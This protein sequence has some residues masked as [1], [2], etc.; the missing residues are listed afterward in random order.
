MDDWYTVVEILPPPGY[1]SDTAPKDVKLEP[2]KATQIK[3]DN[4][5]KPVLVFLKTNG[6]TG[7]GIPGATFRV[8]YET[9]GG[10]LLNIGSYKTDSSGRIII[11]LVNPGWYVLTETL[12]ANG[13]SLPQNPV[14]RLYVSAGQNAYLPEFDKYYGVGANTGQ[15]ATATPPGETHT[16]EEHSG[17]EYYVQGEG[18]NWPLN[19][20]VIKKTHAITGELLAGAAF[21]LYRADE[22]VSGVPGTAVGRYTVDNSGI[23]VITGLLPGYYVV[24]EVQAPQNFLISEN[25]QQNG[26]LK[27]D[28]TAVLEFT[29]ANYPYGSL[30]ITKADAKTSAP[31]AGARFKVTTSEGTVTGSSNG[32]FTTDAKGEILIPNLKPGAYVVTELTAPDGYALS[33]L[34]MTIDIG[35]DG[36]TYTA[37]FTNEPLGSLVIRKLD[38]ATKQPLMGAEFMVTMTDGSVVGASNGVFVTDSAGTIEIPGLARGSYIVKETKA[39]DGYVLENKTQT[40][41]VSYGLAYTVTVE[42]S[43]MSGVQIIKIDTANKQPLKDARFTVYKKS[44]EFVGSY[45]T[46]GDGVIILD[47]LEP[48][49]YKAVESQAPAGYLID[50]TPQDFEVTSNQ[51]IKLIFENKQLSSLQIRKESAVSGDPLP[52]AVFEVRKQNGEYV[53]EYT[54]GKDGSVSIPNAAPGWYVVSETKAPQ[55]YILDSTAKTV[56]VKPITPTVVMFTNKPLSGIEILKI[57]AASKAPLMDAA[58]TVKRDNGEKIGSYKTDQAGKII[59]SGLNEGTYIVSETAAPDGYILDALPQ[60]VIV[61]SGKL[62]VIE[63]TNKPLAGLRIIKLDSVTKSPIEGAQFAVSKMNGEK[64]ENEFRS[65]TFTT[66]DAGQIFIPGLTDGYYLVTETKAADGYIKDGQPKTVLVQSGKT[67]LLEVFNTPQSGLLIVKTDEQTGKPLAGVVFDV[68]RADGQFTA[69]SILDGNQ[70]GTEANSPNKS[71]SPNGD[72]TGSYTTD[73]NGRIQI[74]GLPAGEYHVIERKALDGYELDTGVHSVTVTPG[75]LATLQ[76]T[77]RQKAGLRLLKIDSVTKKPIYGAEFMVFD[78]NNKVVGNYVTDNNGIIDFGGILTEGRYTIRETRPADGYY[79]DDM[80]RTVEF[81]SGKITE[82]VWENTPSMGQV[83]I[84]KLSGDDNEVN[85]LPKGTPLAGAIFEIYNYRS[86]NLVD[87]FVSGADGRAVSKPLP[88]GRYTVKEVQAPRWYKLSTEALDIEI[89]FATQII[90]R[91]FYNYSANT[92]VRI[93]KT[94]VYEAM[95]GNTV[96]YDIKEVGNTS[97]VS[98]TDFFWRDVLP[99]DAVRLDKIVTG[100]Y[101][102]SLK[103]KIL[104]TTNKGDTRVI[105]D[106]LS[107]TVNN[108]IDCRGVALGLRSDEYVTS[109]TLMFG[110]VKAGFAQVLAPQVFV[111]LNKGLTNGYQFAN[112]ADVGGKYYEEWIIGNSTWVTTVYAPP[113]KLPRTGY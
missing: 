94:G 68:R 5:R 104:I 44:G 111:T 47:R 28:G 46:N 27:A 90:K 41:S 31:L 95:P 24:K 105:A 61:R 29:F 58:F 18:Y 108:V 55:G 106:N 54:T 82:V 96:S 7:N 99:T 63:F 88:L 84:T 43:K 66:D 25:S 45:S 36:K 10:G 32:E 14:T 71:T 49:W 19:S 65:Y 17:A 59:V 13:F 40:I 12:P 89:E 51:F 52:G 9:P 92:G 21:E 22:Q 83:Q 8:E 64:V 69:G 97:T 67:S 93:R 107:T 2:G 79:R 112:K 11:P 85:G 109:F 6:L 60:T 73:K 16:A 110:T 42:N 48:G 86:G 38:S 100:T 30:L 74:N 20:V 72:I 34:P 3:F 113:V 98:L 37:A 23:V 81:V 62:T 15:D 39:P 75:K 53:G 33:S 77:N 70:P 91:E 57:D 87:R 101:N 26:Y 35:R 4:T 76:L 103:Y 50:D 102:Q 1:L 56:E 80:P 78:A